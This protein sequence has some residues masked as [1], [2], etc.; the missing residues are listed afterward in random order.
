MGRRDA[1]IETL[2]AK[3][4]SQIEQIRR[5]YEKSLHAKSIDPALRVDIKNACENLR[6][7]LD[8]LATDIREAYCAGAP[9]RSFY[10]PILPDRETFDARLE[11]WFPGLKAAAPSL[12]NELEALQPYHPNQA[13][14]GQFNR[15][16]RENKHGDLVEQ[17][18]VEIKETTVARDG[19]ALTWKSNVTFGPGVSI[20]GAPIDPKTQLPVAGSPVKVKQ[21]IWVDFQFAGIGM[22]ARTLLVQSMA[23][24]SDMVTRIQRLIA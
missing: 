9:R 15:L 3:A 22:S 16:N 12:V 23:G 2:L 20:L 6:S 8:Y 21:V 4:R 17:T 19:S 13:W 18:R 10:F 14:L 24:I 5:E 1:D 7:A 11:Q